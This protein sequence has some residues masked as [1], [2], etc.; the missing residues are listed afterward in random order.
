MTEEFTVPQT[1]LRYAG[2]I[3]MDIRLDEGYW[4][5][6]GVFETIAVENGRAVLLEEHLKRLK[7]GIHFLGL[8]TDTDEDTDEHT[9]E[10]TDKN[11]DKNT[12]K[13]TCKEK[14]LGYLADHPMTHGVL[15]ISVSDENQILTHR[16]NPYG[17][18]QFQTGF[19]AK[20]SQVIRNET[21][22]LTYHKTM[23]YGDCILE[24]RKALDEGY[25]EFI[26]CNSKGEICEGTS[27]NIFFV[28]D[29]AVY[30]PKLSCGLLPGIMRD[31]LL[32]TENIVETVIRPGEISEFEECFLTNS[33]MGIMSVTS[34]EGYTF[35]KRDLAAAWN[36]KFWRNME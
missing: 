12:V 23:N 5:G 28:K 30:T 33:L 9:N 26:F 35:Q 3:N 15:K 32:N 22:P 36:E 21:S 7:K 14:I 16:Q 4:F 24:K 19:R 8:K 25:D 20:F 29:Q 6:L 27:S 11:I 10:N 31:Y 17:S 2:G 18:E 13:S 34:L 1:G